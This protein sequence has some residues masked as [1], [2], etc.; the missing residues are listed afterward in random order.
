MQKLEL[1]LDILPPTGPVVIDFPKLS[2]SEKSQLEKELKEI[3]E[4]IDIRYENIGG[5]ADWIVVAIYLSG[6]FFL[7]DKINKN[8]EAWKNLSLKFFNLFKK[9]KI[10]FI[11][12][13]GARLLAIEKILKNE[14]DVNSLEEI[15][16]KEIV[17]DDLSN[18]FRD[19]RKSNELRSKPFC[20]FNI[21]FK[22]NSYTYYVFGIKSNAEIVNF[23]KLEKSYIN[24]NKVYN[25]KK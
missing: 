8:L 23:N 12:E 19:D 21:I 7:G 3:S 13:N 20:F 6:I 16:F 9:T 15:L 24:F 11:D 14:K 25:L 4:E 5:G 22:V 10:T 18:T 1:L 2:D 17:L